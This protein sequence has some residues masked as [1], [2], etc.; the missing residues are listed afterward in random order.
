MMTPEQIT[1]DFVLFGTIIPASSNDTAM[2]RTR[3]FYR[4]EAIGWAR[5]ARQS[6]TGGGD[7]K[8]ACLRLAKF[9]LARYKEH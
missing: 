2:R 1:R 4:A 5:L 9:Y 6:W 3:Y 7:T 8:A